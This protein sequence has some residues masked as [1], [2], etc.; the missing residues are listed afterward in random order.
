MTN[1]CRLTTFDNPYNPFEDFTQWFLFD[2]SKG[3]NT[4]GLIARLENVS[5]DMTE[6]ESF[7]EHE[8]V[9]NS[10][11]NNDAFNRYKKVYR[12]KEDSKAVNP[13][14]VFVEA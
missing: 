2:V 14:M 5:E 6:Q 12:N 10:I 11:I 1:D 4:C 8:R 13:D 3:Y 7:D 9:I